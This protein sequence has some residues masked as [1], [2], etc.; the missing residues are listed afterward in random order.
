[1]PSSSKFSDVIWN[2]CEEKDLDPEQ[3]IR[4]AVNFFAQ[5]T[6]DKKTAESQPVLV[7]LTGGSVPS[8]TAVDTTGKNR[9]VT[10]ASLYPDIKAVTKM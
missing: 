4:G 5:Y 9:E 10:R 1:M 3:L 8:L 6:D 7:D 2:I